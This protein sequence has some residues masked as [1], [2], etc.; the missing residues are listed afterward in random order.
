MVG[1]MMLGGA[2]NGFWGMIASRGMVKV[3]LILRRYDLINLIAVIL[4]RLFRSERYAFE[5]G[6][7]QLQTQSSR[8]KWFD[9]YVTEK[10]VKGLP[11]RRS[12]STTKVLPRDH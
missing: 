6:T 1:G 3:G 5:A 7:N 2:V 9:K 12:R 4:E 8:S 10:N 11:R